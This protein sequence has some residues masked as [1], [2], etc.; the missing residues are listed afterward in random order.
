MRSIVRATLLLVLFWFLPTL[1]LAQ[2]VEPKY[3]T[4]DPNNA[5]IHGRVVLPSGFAVER[6]ARITLKN[7]QSVIATLYSNK[8]GEFQIRNLSEGVYYVQ[9]EVNESFE[10]VIKKVE[11][12]RGLM[13]DV[14]FELRESP[15]TISTRLGP[16]VVSAA[17]LRQAVP[18]AAKKEYE[19]GLKSVN[20]GDFTQAALHF[21]Q[22]VTLYPEYL[23]AR[24]DLGA[25]YLK[26]KKIDIAEKHFQ[27]VLGND[28]KN[29]NAT[30]NMGLVHIERRDYIGAIAQL[31]LAIALDSTRGVPHLWIGIAKLELGDIPESEAELTKS[32]IM[33]ATEC[34]AAHFYLARVFMTRGDTEEA[35]R[36][37]RAY[38]D[39]APR[40]EYAKEAKALEQQIQKTRK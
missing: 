27:M 29:F 19:L 31:N 40:G 36:S 25:Q 17:E 13:V 14:T 30:F 10:P 33:G 34:V 18:P 16:R 24:N 8:S 28:P 39:E 32:L 5:V 11:L 9:V 37:L 38:L 2:D 6:F 7:T 20:K 26:L 4:P 35:T 12:G 22:A 21:E 15:T 23:A 3:K 1:L